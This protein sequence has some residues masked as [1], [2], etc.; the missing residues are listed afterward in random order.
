MERDDL[1]AM[2]IESA[3]GYELEEL[4]RGR[5]LL[6]FGDIEKHFYTHVIF[7]TDNMIEK[8][9]DALRRFLRGWFKTIAFMRANK[10]GDGEDHV[11][12]DRR[13]RKHRE[14]DLR[15]ADRRLLGRRRVGRRSID[16]I[17]KSLVD[18]G[19]LDKVPEAKT[20]YNDQFVPVKL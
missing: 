16:V 7:A 3:T 4:K 1:D 12:G 6:H 17:R 14:P 9:T 15:R 19:I 10:D 2:V 20:I 5:I 11:Q 13:A 8:R 18:L